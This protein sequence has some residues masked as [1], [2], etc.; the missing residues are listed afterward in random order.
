M[1]IF[2]FPFLSERFHV[3]VSSS[4]SVLV[5]QFHKIVGYQKAPKHNPVRVSNAKKTKQNKK[6]PRTAT[7]DVFRGCLYPVE[8]KPSSFAGHFF[9]MCMHLK[10]KKKSRKPG[11]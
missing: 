7:E 5:L 6:P 4:P 3:T 8:V 10:K 2:F 1:H 11:T 9:I